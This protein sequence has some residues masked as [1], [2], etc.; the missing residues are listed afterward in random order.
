MFYPHTQQARGQRGKSFSKDQVWGK[1]SSMFIQS[2]N[3]QSDANS[4][5]KN[6]C[7]EE[8]LISS[9]HKHNSLE[10]TRHYW[11]HAWRGDKN[12]AFLATNPRS[13]SVENSN[14]SILMRN[15]VTVSNFFSLKESQFLPSLLA[16]I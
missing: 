1:K 16:T 15:G 6:S 2:P 13:E 10:F 7:P 14:I 8:S 5:S 12:R 11:N 9:K 4:R 3:L